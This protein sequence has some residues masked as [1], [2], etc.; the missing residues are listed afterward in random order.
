MITAKDA[1]ERARIAREKYIKNTIAEAI[2]EGYCSMIFESERIFDDI[3]NLEP[4]LKKLGYKVIRK[5]HKGN[6]GREYETIE[7]S[8]E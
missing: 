8:W 3:E 4:E 1:K 6:F 5:N 2:D 7:V